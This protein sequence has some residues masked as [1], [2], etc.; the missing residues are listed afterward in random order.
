MED[1]DF[2]DITASFEEKLRLL[3]S[4]PYESSAACHAR[5]SLLWLSQKDLGLLSKP[6]RECEIDREQWQTLQAAAANFLRFCER[7]AWGEFVHYYN[8]YLCADQN[9]DELPLKAIR[10]SDMRRFRKAHGQHE[11]SEDAEV[12]DALKP[13]FG[14]VVAKMTK[15]LQTNYERFPDCDEFE[16]SWLLILR[17]E[18]EQFARKNP[19]FH[20]AIFVSAIEPLLDYLTVPEPQRRELEEFKTLAPHVVGFISS[21]LVK[22]L[23][24]LG[25]EARAHELTI[26]LSC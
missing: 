20:S 15:E 2:V 8:Q 13:V 4:T 17:Q 9:G 21:N 24:K 11:E 10:A 25:Y 18:V 6:N 1:D 14:S 16:I 3:C 7:K 19:K 23:K 22:R 12:Y 26:I 5:I